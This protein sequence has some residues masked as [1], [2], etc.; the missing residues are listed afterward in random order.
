MSVANLSSDRDSLVPKGFQQIT[1]LTAST[2][3]TVPEGAQIAIIQAEDN[4]VRWRDDG[5]APT[6]TVGM[7]LQPQAANIND[8]LYY[9]GDLDALRFIQAAATAEISVAYYAMSGN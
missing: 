2:G 1:T 5:T 6:A 9:Q 3:L 7:L 4:A 8:T